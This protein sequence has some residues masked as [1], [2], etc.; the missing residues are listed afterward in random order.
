M[1]AINYLI[2]ILEAGYFAND[3]LEKKTG[4]ELGCSLDTIFLDQVKL[5]LSRY[6]MTT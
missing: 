6:I 3:S 4:L 5:D 2:V 1:L